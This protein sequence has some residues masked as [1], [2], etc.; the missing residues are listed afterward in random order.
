M[1]SQPFT[2]LNIN[3][4]ANRLC[5]SGQRIIIQL[6]SAISRYF[7]SAVVSVS[8]SSMLH[9]EGMSSAQI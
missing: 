9:T 1:S 6:Y 4:Q 8:A 3:F 2:L 7:N 5:A